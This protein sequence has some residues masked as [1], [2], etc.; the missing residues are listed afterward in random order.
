MPSDPTFSFVF[1]AGVFV[2]FVCHFDACFFPRG[3]WFD[4]GSSNGKTGQIVLNDD[5]RNGSTAVG[6][7]LSILTGKK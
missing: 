3:S 4:S 5:S 6:L 2:Q 1:L 7:F